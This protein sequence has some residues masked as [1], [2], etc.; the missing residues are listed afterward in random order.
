MTGRSG[1]LRSM[2]LTLILLAAVGDVAAVDT[3]GSDP[4]EHSI[5]IWPGEERGLEI[6]IRNSWPYE[7]T[8][9]LSTE[10]VECGWKCPT[11]SVKEKEIYL[12]QNQILYFLEYDLKY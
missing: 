2:V 11:L 12:A 6:V 4:T 5:T 8:G 10:I 3:V 1:P 7:L 9:E